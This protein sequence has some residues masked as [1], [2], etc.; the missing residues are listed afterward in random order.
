VERCR[1]EDGC[2]GGRC[3]VMEVEAE[4]VS[5]GGMAVGKVVLVVLVVLGCGG[6][7]SMSRTWACMFYLGAMAV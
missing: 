5:V 1:D 7:S 3:V 6:T 2:G 4:V